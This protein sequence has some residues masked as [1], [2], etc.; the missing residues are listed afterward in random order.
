VVRGGTVH[1]GDHVVLHRPDDPLGGAPSGW[2]RRP[3][4]PRQPGTSGIR[5]SRSPRA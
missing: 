1:M 4:A 5:N 2:S 3:A